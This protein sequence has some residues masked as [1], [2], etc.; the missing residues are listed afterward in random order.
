MKDQILR[1]ISETGLRMDLEVLRSVWSEFDEKER[2]ARNDLLEY[3][4]SLKPNSPKSVAEYFF[5]QKGVSKVNRRST[6]ERVLTHLYMNGH[7]E[8]M[9]IMNVRKAIKVKSQIVSL[10]SIAG[11][12]LQ[13]DVRYFT[14]KASFI[15]DSVTGR[16]YLKDPNILSLSRNIR[17]AVVPK[18]GNVFVNFD[19][20]QQEFLI[21]AKAADQTEVIEMVKSGKDVFEHMARKWGITRGEVKTTFYAKM[22]RQRP[23]Q[24]AIILNCTEERARELHS[25]FDKTYPKI[26]KYLFHREYCI[27]RER[28]A[29]TLIAGR[30]YQI[31]DT[32]D[33]AKEVRRGLSFEIQ[34]TGAD[35]MDLIL[36]DEE[37]HSKLSS[38]GARIVVPVWDALL[39]ECPE[40][41]RNVVE[42]FVS[43]K[44]CQIPTKCGFP[45][46]VSTKSGKNWFEVR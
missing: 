46:F 10:L 36:N 15:P 33:L 22:Y 18:E 43:H 42:S 8:A 45:Q 5:D 26:S 9:L 6:D 14:L 17:K 13:S 11:I 25:S 29:R 2:S 38:L 12:D 1:D 16:L 37:L 31:R 40:E 20:D 3:S 30:E 34:G 39:I 35:I 44:M 23:H 41:F 24:L 7:E 27:P 28:V 32:L 4:L 19:Y 21:V